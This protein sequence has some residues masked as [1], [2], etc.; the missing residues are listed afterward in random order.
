MRGVKFRTHKFVL[1]VL[2]NR[3][4]LGSVKVS[5]PLVNDFFFFFTFYCVAILSAVIMGCLQV[6]H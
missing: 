2:G 4:K 5:C 6:D 3:G 1:F